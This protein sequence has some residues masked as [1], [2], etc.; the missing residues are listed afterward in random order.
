MVSNLAYGSISL[1]NRGTRARKLTSATAGI[2]MECVDGSNTSCFIGCFTRDYGDMIA[3]HR[4]GVP[5]YHST[6]SGTTMM[7]NRVSWFF[8]LKGA[9]VTLD[10]ACSSSLAAL[11]LACQSLRAGETNL[12]VVGGTNVMFMPDIMGAMTRVNFLSPDGKC[13]SFD[14]KANGYSRGEGKQQPPLWMGRSAFANSIV[15]SVFRCC[16]L[17]VKTSASSN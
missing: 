13:Q 4:T 5:R 10:T 1:K 3:T 2:P 12:S 6:G 14:H 16:V 9:S 11:H 7:A 17:C 15:S 8:N